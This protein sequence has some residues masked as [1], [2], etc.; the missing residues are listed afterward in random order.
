MLAA[1]RRNRIIEE[2]NRNKSIIVSDLSEA[3]LV[4][5][6]TIRR[7]LDK[8]QKQGCLMRTYGGATLPNDSK[9][10]FPAKIREGL[11]TE[12]KIRIAKKAAEL[13]N[14]GD[15]IFIDASSSSYYLSKEIKSK[16]ITV[17][18]NA[19]NV[20]AELSG[21]TEVT[22]IS[23]GGKMDPNHLAFFGPLAVRAI[24][25]FNAGKLF[26]SCKGISL[27]AGL[28]DS[29]ELISESHKTMIHKAKEVILLCDSSKFGMTSF[30]GTA[31]FDE[32]DV[33]I[34]EKKLPAD[35]EDMARMSGTAL[36]YVSGSESPNAEDNH[37]CY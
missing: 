31:S 26:F 10:D 4:S 8:L 37:L 23:T 21:E 2:I 34:T 11:N 24:E 36:I 18:T 5:E 15:C 19:L 29:D 33:M 28:T 16:R 3:Y 13:I 1:E 20:I 30:I 22:I 7:D 32:I 6:E 14:D 12:A 9:T 35:W 25:Q 17:I 27:E